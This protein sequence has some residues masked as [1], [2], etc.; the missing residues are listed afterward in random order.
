MTFTEC[1][2]E[3]TTTQ[4]QIPNFMYKISKISCEL[5]QS[6]KYVPI[7]SITVPSVSSS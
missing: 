5:F 1:L 6:Y 4:L 2:H 7:F 3:K